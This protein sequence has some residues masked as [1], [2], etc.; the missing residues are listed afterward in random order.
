M[1]LVRFTP[2]LCGITIMKV[3]VLTKTPQNKVCPPPPFPCHPPLFLV[4]WV[5]KGCRLGVCP[6]STDPPPHR[7]RPGCAGMD[8]PDR[9]EELTVYSPTSLGWPRG[10]DPPTLSNQ[11]RMTW[12][13]GVQ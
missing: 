9:N 7:H 2:E 4:L 12:G 5:E 8:Q 11:K 3:S 1:E 10:L 6:L 13:G